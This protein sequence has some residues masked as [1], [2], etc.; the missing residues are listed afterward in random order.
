MSV[1]FQAQPTQPAVLRS[2]ATL[3]GTPAL[4]YIFD[5][6]INSVH[7]LGDDVSASPQVIV[8]ISSVIPATLAWVTRAPAPAS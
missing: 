6:L 1:S 3:G 2:V 5:W 7:V 4:Y 8:A